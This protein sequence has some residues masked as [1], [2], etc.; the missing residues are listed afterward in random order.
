MIAIMENTAMA[1]MG[2]VGAGVFIERNS[3]IMV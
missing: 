1:L 2:R 3:L